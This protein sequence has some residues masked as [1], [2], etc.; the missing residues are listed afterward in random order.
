MHD[1]EGRP[2]V[3]D[4]NPRPGAGTAM[5]GACGVDFLAAHVAM[6]LGR[7]PAPFLPQLAGERFVVRTYVEILTR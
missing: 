1:G 3:I 2:L 5:S 4:V 7:D 6:A